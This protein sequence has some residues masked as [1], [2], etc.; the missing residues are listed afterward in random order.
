MTKVCL[1]KLGGKYRECYVTLG[2]ARCGVMVHAPLLFLQTLGGLTG[3]NR[4]WA[5]HVTQVGV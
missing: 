5:L 1:C 3:S 2:S 4:F